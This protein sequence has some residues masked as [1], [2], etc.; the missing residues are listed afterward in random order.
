MHLATAQHYARH[1]VPWNIWRQSTR[2]EELVRGPVWMHRE[3]WHRLR[4]RLHTRSSPGTRYVARG[5]ERDGD[6]MRL[7]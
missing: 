7:L 2:G 5:I 4:N 1:I 6:Q 3:Q